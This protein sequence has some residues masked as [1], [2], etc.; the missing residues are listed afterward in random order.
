MTANPKANSA[1]MSQGL[2]CHCAKWAL[3]LAI[4]PWIHGQTPQE[5]VS[6]GN[7]AR[8]MPS[9]MPIGAAG[10]VEPG[11]GCAKHICRKPRRA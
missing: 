10:A 1:A 5:Q 11:K 7:L 6:R 3:Q 8:E 4:K 9:R 2:F